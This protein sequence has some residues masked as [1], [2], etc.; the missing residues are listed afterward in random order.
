[1]IVCTS[2]KDDNNEN[3]KNIQF[4]M[5]SYSVSTIFCKA[6]RIYTDNFYAY[7]Y[8]TEDEVQVLKNIDN[9]DH[10]LL[11]YAHDTLAAVF[12]HQAD[13]GKFENELFGIDNNEIKK[14]LE[15]YYSDT[16]F[17]DK[18]STDNWHYA[19]KWH[20]FL[21]ENIEK[22]IPFIKQIVIA[23]LLSKS[24]SQNDEAWKA[25]NR[26]SDIIKEQYNKIQWVSHNG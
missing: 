7:L 10:R 17:L 9:Y 20:D 16:D 19:L 11:Q 26:A 14:Q 12:R 1:M 8:L 5:Y 6:Q 23:T 15:T 18:I 22:N 13:E 25:A 4:E 2:Y 24:N 21:L 3:L